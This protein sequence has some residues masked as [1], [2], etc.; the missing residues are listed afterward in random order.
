MA[1]RQESALRRDFID[2]RSIELDDRVVEKGINRC[3]K[4]MRGGRRFSFSALVVAGDRAG[5][6]G[7]GFGKARDVPSAVEKA[8]KDAR[9]NLVR[10]E[11]DGDTVPHRVW[12]RFGAAKVL[13]LPAAPGTGVIAGPCVRAVLE[14]VGIKNIL[15]KSYGSGNAVNLV[16]ATLSGLEQL[17]SRDE[18]MRLRGVES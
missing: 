4:V 5:I 18:V 12:G 13:M 1:L 15:T 2:P 14:L 7:C 17:R 10:V 16:K 8:T 6:V 9:K 3:A 11:L